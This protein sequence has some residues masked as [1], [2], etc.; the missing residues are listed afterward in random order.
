ME[1]AGYIVAIA[2]SSSSSFLSFF[3]FSS[4]YFSFLSRQ[5]SRIPAA[6]KKRKKE[7]E[8]FLTHCLL[9]T[10][11]EVY[12]YFASASIQSEFFLK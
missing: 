8:S 7:K 1:R 5:F 6:S 3:L 9:N 2:P 4:F 10:F 11:I 12:I